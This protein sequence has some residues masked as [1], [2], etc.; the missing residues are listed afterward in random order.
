M[1]YDEAVAW[2]NG[3]RSMIN[4]I[5]QHPFE[6]WIVRV[7]EADCNMT[8]QAYWIVRAHNERPGRTDEVSK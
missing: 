8:Q 4:T 5:P 7:S 3:E 6:T 2:L 1:T